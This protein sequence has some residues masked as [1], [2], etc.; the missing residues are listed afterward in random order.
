MNDPLR[1][2]ARSIA[3]L[4]AAHKAGRISAAQWGRLVA[5]AI[6]EFRV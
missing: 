5:V 2:L 3:R 1:P 4:N 6:G